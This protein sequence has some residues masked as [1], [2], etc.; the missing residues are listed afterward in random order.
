M[1]SELKGF[2]ELHRKLAKLGPAIGGKVLRSAAMTATLPALKM[3]R[4]RAP[5]GEIVYSYPYGEREPYPKSTHKGR[6]VGPG[7]GARSLARKSIISPDKTRVTV[8]IGPR[9]EA[10]YMTQFVELGTSRQ[11]AQPFL[12]PSFRAMRGMMIDR[13]RSQLRLKIEKVAR[14]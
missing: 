1:A 3:A 13:L 7:F 6:L 4:A 9:P 10:F 14:Q 12:E 8:L 11:A 5:Q 2:E